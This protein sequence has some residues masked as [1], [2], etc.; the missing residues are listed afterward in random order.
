MAA[1]E[2]M[3]QAAFRRIYPHDL[4]QQGDLWELSIESDEDWLLPRAKDGLRITHIGDEP[5]V[6]VREKYLRGPI[7]VGEGDRVVDVGAMVGEFS[8]WLPTEDILAIDPDPRNVQCLRSNTEAEV[9]QAAAWCSD[10]TKTLT[11]GPDTSESSLLDL[12]SGTGDTQ[13]TQAI[14]LDG[15]ITGRVDLLKVEAEG[16]EPEVLQGAAGVDAE[17]IVVDVS[18]ERNGQSPAPLCRALLED[19]GYDV[20]RHD[21]IL[22][23]VQPGDSDD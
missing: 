23:A 5:R 1:V 11:L 2:A 4:S 7:S 16:A 12:D 15:L 22:T 14:R 13:Q 3:P 17:Q 9:I 8:R 20:E 6:R 19:R 21:D 18:P 10:R